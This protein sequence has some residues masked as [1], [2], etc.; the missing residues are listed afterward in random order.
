MHPNPLLFCSTTITGSH[1]LAEGNRGLSHLAP[2]CHLLL[3]VV[4]SLS[5]ED[6]LYLSSIVTF[7]VFF[8]LDH[9]HPPHAHLSI[10]TAHVL[11]S[12]SLQAS[13]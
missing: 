6:V 1:L 11:R 10:S 2:T 8:T 12:N 13:E 4:C 3:S 9:V 7:L 5:L